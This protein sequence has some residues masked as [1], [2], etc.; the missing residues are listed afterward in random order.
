MVG[1][2]VFTVDEADALVPELE[3]SFA[4]IDEL[5]DALRTTKIKLNAL[6]MIWGP[7][8]LEASCPDASEAKALV[9]QLKDVEDRV[10]STLRRLAEL[11]AT[12]KDVHSGLVDLYHVREGRLVFLCWKRGEAE[13]VAWHDV[14]TGFA[15]RHAL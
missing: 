13:F 14:D 15:D 7:A 2:R 12:V 4:R 5:R 10:G 6:E 3:A 9:E 11:G 1:P 8:L